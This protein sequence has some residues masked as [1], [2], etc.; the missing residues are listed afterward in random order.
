MLT[1]L[2]QNR[3]AYDIQTAH[4]AYHHPGRG[5]AILA[6]GEVIARVGEVHPD[7]MEQ[8]DLSQRA[9]LAEVNLELLLQMA[10]PLDAV[11]PLPK[12]PA[13]PRDLALV[14]DQKQELLPVMQ[15]IQKAGGKLLEDVRL[16]DVF[17]GAQVGEGKK[18][19]AF[20][21]RLRHPEKTLEE[22]EINQVIDKVIRKLT[23]RFQAQIRS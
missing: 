21:L 12:T 6:N 14:L 19:A 22:A 10:K 1:L 4:E 8:F 2:T 5:A 23:D 11:T 15:E 7:I 9:V 16:F 13:V 20:A 17:Q 3:I 18:S